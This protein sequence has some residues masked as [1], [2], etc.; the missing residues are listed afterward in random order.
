MKHTINGAL[1]KTLLMLFVA[2]IVLSGCSTTGS[3][4]DHEDNSDAFAGVDEFYDGQ[5]ELVYENKKSP[6]TA[7]EMIALGDDA[8]ARGKAD[9]A[10][11]QY[12]KAIDLDN[13]SDTALCKIGGIHAKRGNTATAMKAYELALEINP[14]RGGA[15]EGLALL[16]LNKRK[17]DEARDHLTKAEANGATINWRIY[18][19]LGVISD[20][21][22]DYKQ[23]IIYYQK[24]LAL[25]PELPIILNN[26]G[27]SRYMLG[28]WDSAEK[29]YRKA[30]LND[31]YFK[32]AWRNLGLLYSRKGNY[33][34]A[35]SAFTQVENLPE[36]YN[37]IGYICMLDERYDISE[38]FF[39]RA[40]KLAPRY[41]VTANNNLQKNRRLSS[42]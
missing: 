17:Y 5:S 41:Y 28:D 9:E 27:Y 42:K 6:E 7:K 12:V 13:T 37:D 40:I 2:S 21:E 34:Q 26:M 20:L 10:L 25:Q 15:H 19:S 38:A 3:I 18:N 8:M 31:K 24:A 30:V 39:K 1:P 35:I 16:L 4:N 36:A 22:N 11:Y 29:Y 23:A 33:D 14:D 32:R